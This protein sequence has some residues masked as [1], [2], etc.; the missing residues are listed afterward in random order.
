MN[1]VKESAVVETKISPFPILISADHG[2]LKYIPQWLLNFYHTVIGPPKPR[3][4]GIFMEFGKFV[5]IQNKESINDLYKSGS[6]GKGDL[7]R[8]NPTWF[9]RTVEQDKNALEEITV[10]RRKKRRQKNKKFVEE[11]ESKDMLNPSELLNFTSNLDVEVFQLDL[12]ESFFLKY[13]LNALSIVDTKQVRRR[14]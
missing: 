14:Y 11:Q 6:F 12:Y 10:A 13:A 7:S 2:F 3:I 8:S 4:N 5:W 9:T 1:S